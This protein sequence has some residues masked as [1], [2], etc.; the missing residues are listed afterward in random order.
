M[1][2]A[3]FLFQKNFGLE[4][5]LESNVFLKKTLYL[6]T[7]RELNP[8]DEEMAILVG[9]YNILNYLLDI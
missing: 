5:L 4:H 1:N 9:K 2:F 7:N 8:K 6:T 3:T